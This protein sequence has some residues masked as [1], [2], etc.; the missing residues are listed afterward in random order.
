MLISVAVG[1]MLLGGWVLSSPENEEKYEPLVEEQKP[2]VMAP[3]TPLIPPSMDRRG[4][5]SKSGGAA[6]GQALGMMPTAPTES[7]DPN[8]AGL[9]G[10]PS[11]PTSP[12][13]EDLEME[14][15][16]GAYRSR[17]P[18]VPTSTDGRYRPSSR[19]REAQARAD[20]RVKGIPSPLIQQQPAPTQITMPPGMEKAFSGYRAPSGVSPYM[21]LFRSDSG[22]TIDNYTSL[23][24]PQLEQRYMNQQLGRDINAE[25]NAR[26]Q[27]QMQLQMQQKRKLQGV[28]TPS[29]YMTSPK[30][31]MMG[32]EQQ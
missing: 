9:M 6:R 29:F 31:N 11:A 3:S 13:S 24:R 25:R 21:N 1:T 10:H 4:K 8:E 19:S 22:G 20:M 16:Q 26:I 28:E 15:G 7:I 27:Q 23:V 12:D 32:Y 2:R 18:D 17:Q 30:Y 14:I 5:P